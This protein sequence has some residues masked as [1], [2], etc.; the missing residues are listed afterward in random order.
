[1]FSSRQDDRPGKQQNH[2]RSNR[3]REIG[4]HMLD[5]DFGEN[6]SRRGC[7]RGP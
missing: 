3:R 6:G 7:Q 5:T 1:M 4:R 2:R